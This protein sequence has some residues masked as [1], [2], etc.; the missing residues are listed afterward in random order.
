MIYV[1]AGVLRLA[2]FNLTS[3]A[4]EK[5]RWT[6]GVPTPVGAG[7]LMVV[8]LM[9]DELPV[10]AAASVV[11]AM[12]LLMVSRLHLPELQ[13]RGAVTVTLLI[14]LANYLAVMVWTNWYTIAWWNLWNGVILLAARAEVRRRQRAEDSPVEA[15][16]LAQV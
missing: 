8:A 10:A 15:E 7:Y 6:T 13:G 14:G 2:R 12:A 11:L 16:D 1:L 5:S 9:A 4:H 3:D